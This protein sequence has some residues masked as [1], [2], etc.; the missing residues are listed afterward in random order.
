MAVS[1]LL[2]PV[3]WVMPVES[4]D[5]VRVSAVPLSRDD[6]HAVSDKAISEPRMNVDERFMVSLSSAAPRRHHHS[7][8]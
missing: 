7:R 8:E 3:S 1:M 2:L 6:L 4:A 5:P